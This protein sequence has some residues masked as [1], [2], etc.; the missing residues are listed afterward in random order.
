MPDLTP[1]DIFD[2]LIAEVPVK[3][4]G[5]DY[6][7]RE[8]DGEVSTIFQNAQIEGT[9]FNSAGETL[10][11]KGLAN[12]Q[13]ILVSLCLYTTDDIPIRVPINKVKSWPSRT[14]KLLFER[15]KEISLLNEQEETLETLKE[16]LEKL[17]K[18]ISEKEELEKNSIEPT[19]D[20]SN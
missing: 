20:G 5:V 3:I 12:I 7:L 9:T 6:I 15:A 4:Q 11:V 2:N 13:P 17:K 19:K 18:T 10:S 8:A 1:I 16:K 14:V